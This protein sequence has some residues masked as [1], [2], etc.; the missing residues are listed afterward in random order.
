VKAGGIDLGGRA[1]LGN[2]PNHWINLR[3]TWA[4]TPRHEVDLALRQYGALPS[5][6]IPAYAALDARVAWKVTPA[7]ELSL[8]VQNITDDKHVEWSNL[9]VQQRSAFLRVTWR[10]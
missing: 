1:L 4:P 8:V 6:H 3:A 5:P 9:V 2:D 10:Q 7:F